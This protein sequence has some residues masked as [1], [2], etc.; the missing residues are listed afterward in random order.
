MRRVKGRMGRGPVGW[1]V[2]ELGMSV[3]DFAAARDGRTEAP[4]GVLRGSSMIPNGLMAHETRWNCSVDD[5][6]FSLH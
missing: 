4:A 5:I 6:V 1:A 3:V 2:D